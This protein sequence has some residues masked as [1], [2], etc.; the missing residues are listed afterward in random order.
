MCILIKFH[1]SSI[2]V[3]ASYSA[4]CGREVC[5]SLYLEKKIAILDLLKDGE[6]NV[7]VSLALNS[8]L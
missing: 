5:F 2:S 1:Y 7:K 6:T 4:Y 8:S 3:N